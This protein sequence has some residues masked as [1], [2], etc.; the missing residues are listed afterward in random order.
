M[1]CPGCKV[2][3]DGRVLAAA[4]LTYAEAK[5]AAGGPHSA[6]LARLARLL[7]RTA[8]GVTDALEFALRSGAIKPGSPELD[9]AHAMSELS[10]HR[11]A[12]LR[13]N[14]AFL[15]APDTSPEDRMKL[16]ML[17]DW[18]E[19]LRLHATKLFGGEYCGAWTVDGI[20]GITRRS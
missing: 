13:E 1:S 15:G 3:I 5:E 4:A 2:I 14:A 8:D 9:E 6:N 18:A 16:F 19:E 10:C 11:A 17:R 20:I 12:M 7:A